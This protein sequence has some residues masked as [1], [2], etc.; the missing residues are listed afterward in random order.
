MHS[1]RCMGLGGAAQAVEA[2]VDLDG[3]RTGSFGRLRPRE[4]GNSKNR[5]RQRGVNRCEMETVAARIYRTLAQSYC[6]Q[7]RAK[8]GQPSRKQQEQCI[9]NDATSC[10]ASSFP[11][12]KTDLNHDLDIHITAQL[13]TKSASLAAVLVRLV[14]CCCWCSHLKR[15]RS[16]W[17]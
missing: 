9:Y 13:S 17:C 3:A 5:T 15:S 14:L 2:A 8:R 7:C 4:A 1:S 10:D 16:T 12:S 11:Q 6:C